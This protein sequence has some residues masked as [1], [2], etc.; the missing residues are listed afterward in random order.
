MHI[1]T[2]RMHSHAN[3]TGLVHRVVVD[4]EGWGRR[5][6]FEILSRRAGKTRDAAARNDL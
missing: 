5:D 1:D 2:Y 4:D 3:A 6:F